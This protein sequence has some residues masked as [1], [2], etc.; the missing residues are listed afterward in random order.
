MTIVEESLQPVSRRNSSLGKQL[1]VASPE[2]A[3]DGDDENPEFKLPK[4]SSLVVVLVTNFLMQVFYTFSNS[5]DFVL[6]VCLFQ[7]PDLFFHHRPVVQR[8]HGTTGRWRDILR[9]RHRYSS[10]DLR[11]NSCAFVEI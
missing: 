7:T 6:S 9:S 3:I 11:I 5:T 8:V 2:E 4:M 1:P 10:L